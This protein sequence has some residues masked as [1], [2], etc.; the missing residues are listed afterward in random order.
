MIVVRSSIVQVDFKTLHIHI[1]GK[2]KA[3]L[4]T[5]H[6]NFK[7]NISKLLKICVGLVTFYFQEYLLL[8][9]VDA[10]DNNSF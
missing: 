9:L 6:V 8:D 10:I 1:P 5:V 3:T 4:S 7:T 2:R